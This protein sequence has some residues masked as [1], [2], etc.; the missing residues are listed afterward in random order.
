M[1]PPSTRHRGE[2][3]GESPATPGLFG[4]GLTKREQLAAMAM[5]GLLADPQC[6][7]DRA[8][9]ARF[10]VGMADALLLELANP[11]PWERS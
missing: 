4:K 11:L 10:A 7:P 9:V 6:S 3:N 1:N 5:Q 8:A 2:R